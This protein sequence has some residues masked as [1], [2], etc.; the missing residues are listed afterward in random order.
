MYKLQ[1]AYGYAVPDMKR[2]TLVLMHILIQSSYKSIF[3]YK[4]SG[5]TET[6]DNAETH[7]YHL[8]AR[9]G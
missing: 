4:T 3:S 5:D 8:Q 1:Y 7:M 9:V 6:S 2:I